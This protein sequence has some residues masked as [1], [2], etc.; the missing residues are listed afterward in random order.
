MNLSPFVDTPFED[1]EAWEAFEL[2]HGASH[3]KIFQVLAKLG[4]PLNHYPLFDLQENTD[5]KL[6]HQQEH[7]SIFNLLGLTGLPD[8]TS[9][10][11]DKRDEFEDWMAYHAQVHARINAALGITS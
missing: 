6:I 7:Q 8:M 9:M 4:K 10:D 5:W 3:E 11:L 2:A 1:P